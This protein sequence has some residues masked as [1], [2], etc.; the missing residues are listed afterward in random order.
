MESVLLDAA[1]HGRS[2][3]TMPATT[4]AVRP[5]T[6]TSST[7]RPTDGREIVSV[8]CTIGDRAKGHRLRALIVLL[9]RAVLVQASRPGRSR[10]HARRLA[11]HAPSPDGLPAEPSCPDRGSSRL[12]MRAHPRRPPQHN[13]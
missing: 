7:G 2:P 13:Q 8:M 1:G 12:D 3:A 6:R 10:A 11:P 5:A 4:E 9:W